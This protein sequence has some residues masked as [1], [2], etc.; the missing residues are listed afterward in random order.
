MISIQSHL[1]W[2]QSPVL[3][4]RPG[5]PDPDVVD[6]E[7]GVLPAVA[8]RVP[9]GVPLVSGGPEVRGAVSPSVHPGLGVGS[10]DEGVAEVVDPSHRH[11]QDQVELQQ[12]QGQRGRGTSVR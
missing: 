9:G 10:V 3:R 5:F 11:V 1:C 6:L 12:G 4:V 8:V 7:G 2:S